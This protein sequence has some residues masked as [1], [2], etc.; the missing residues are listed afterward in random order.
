MTGIVSLVWQI[1]THRRSGRLVTVK[2]SYMIPVYGPHHAP[3]FH[4]DDQVTITVSN[5]GGALVTVT[6]YGVAMGGKRSQSNLFVMELPIWAT[7]LPVSVEPGGKLAQVV[8][9]V[10]ELRRAHKEHGIPFRKMR[11]WVD[12]GDGR[13][14]YS[15]NAVPLK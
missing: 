4:D 15:K 14:A 3:E 6:N 9:P 5:Q 11:P 10:V 13:R 8:V 12:L 1:V 7:K 2:S